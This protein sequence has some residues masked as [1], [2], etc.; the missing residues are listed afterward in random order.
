MESYRNII[1]FLSIIGISFTF[2]FYIVQILAFCK[3]LLRYIPVK[4]REQPR[5]QSVH[6][7]LWL[8]KRIVDNCIFV[9]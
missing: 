4:D 7:S 8:G 3:S 2:S 1:L 6:L 9:L 5:I